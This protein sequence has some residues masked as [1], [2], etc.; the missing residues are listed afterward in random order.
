VATKLRRLRLNRCDLVDKPA[1]PHAQV[2]IFKRAPSFL[3]WDLAFFAKKVQ[4][5][6][7]KEEAKPGGLVEALNVTIASSYR[8]YI[9]AH[10]AHWNVEGAMFP[11]WHGFFA[12]LYEDVFGAI[13]SFAESIRQH[14]AY[15]PTSFGE[16]L[17]NDLGSKVGAPVPALIELNA[18]HMNILT[19][20]RGAADA[21]PD[22]G[23]ANF[24]QERMA[25]HLK[26]DWQLRAMEK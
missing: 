25:K 15:A 17:G 5:E 1:N 16:I 7:P 13:D 26:Y 10:S 14:G 21:A 19:A 18:A 2:V 20:L 24:C 8:L 23:L 22:E 4:E 12:S 9:I 11:A 6:T 3:E